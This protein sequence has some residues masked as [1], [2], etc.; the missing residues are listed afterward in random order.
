M[1]NKNGGKR[2]IVGRERGRVS[3]PRGRWDDDERLCTIEG[4]VGYCC[5]CDREVDREFNGAWSKCGRLGRVG[6]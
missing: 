4:K 2:K 6:G 5:V 3:E 1:F